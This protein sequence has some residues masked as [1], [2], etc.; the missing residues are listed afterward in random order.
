MR[1]TRCVSN[2]IVVPNL[3]LFPSDALEVFWSRIHA[4]PAY[5]SGLIALVHLTAAVYRH[6]VRSDGTLLRMRHP[7]AGRDRHMLT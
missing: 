3:P 1:L 2:L 6:R 5:T 7:S 4:L